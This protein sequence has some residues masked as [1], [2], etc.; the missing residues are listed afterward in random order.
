V[1]TVALS[2]A[3][4]VGITLFH[5]LTRDHLHDCCDRIALGMSYEQAK[6]IVDEYGLDLTGGSA[7]LRE[8]VFVYQGRFD[9]AALVVVIDI[10]GQVASKE[11][12]PR[13]GR[14][15]VLDR[16]VDLVGMGPRKDK[17]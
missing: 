5:A 3:G 15:G 10:D 9:T 2:L 13:Y 7:N 12:D 17:Y 8:A 11:I 6:A 16:L 4:V 1:L 14:N